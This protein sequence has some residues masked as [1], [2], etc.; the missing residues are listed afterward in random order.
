MTYGSNPLAA[1]A[2]SPSERRQE[3]CHLLALG[4]IRLHLR[5]SDKDETAPGKRECSTTHSAQSERH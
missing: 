1:S 3:L 2:L 5:H 4:L